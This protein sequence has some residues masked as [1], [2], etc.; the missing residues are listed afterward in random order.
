MKKLLTVW[1][2]RIIIMINF[3]L[4]LFLLFLLEPNFA[5]PA[6]DKVKYVHSCLQLGH[7]WDVFCFETLFCIWNLFSILA[8]QLRADWSVTLDR[9]DNKY[10]VT[11]G[12]SLTASV[13]PA[14]DAGKDGE[15][16]AVVVSGG[17]LLL[18][19]KMLGKLDQKDFRQVI[20]KGMKTYG[21]F[22]ES[23]KQRQVGKFYN[24][25]LCV[26]N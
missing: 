6:D 16:A 12:S 23:S 22:W 24:G 13:A 10:Y 1:I 14:S 2:L 15:G 9:L 4:F 18:Q 3:F 5:N 20:S 17:S 21:K 11:W 25:F 7:Y 26:N 8:S 19:G